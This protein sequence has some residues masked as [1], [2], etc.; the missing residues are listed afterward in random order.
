MLGYM[1]CAMVFGA[2]PA[3]GDPATNLSVLIA[4]PTRYMK[5]TIS[6]LLP[7]RESSKNCIN[8]G[9]PNAVMAAFPVAKLASSFA[10]PYSLS[11]F[12]A[13]SHCAVVASRVALLSAAARCIN[14]APR[15]TTCCAWVCGSL[16][17]FASPSN[18][19]KTSVLN[20]TPSGGV[21]SYFSGTTGAAAAAAAAAGLAAAA[22]AAATAAAP[23]GAAA[24][25]AAEAATA[26]GAAVAAGAAAP[27]AA[28][29]ASPDGVAV[30]W[31]WLF[32]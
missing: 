17:S 9:V 18:L 13:A 14:S 5:R 27:P 6:G 28:A 32:P 26:L 2:L 3:P 23:V 22:A 19:P 20:V 12:A 31:F 10:P 24:E 25:A 29:A 30:F 16:S 7:K 8:S 1:L 11:L 4:I 15:L 21:N